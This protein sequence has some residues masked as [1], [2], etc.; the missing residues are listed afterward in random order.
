MAVP[1]G[2]GEK[3]LQTTTADKGREGCCGQK[4][5]LSW[6][7]GRAPLSRW[8]ERKHRYARL[9][10]ELR[11]N[12]PR[13]WNTATNHDH[14]DDHRVKPRGAYGQELLDTHVP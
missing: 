5:R 4:P 14:Y 10:A 9:A 12:T 13:M 7:C 3:E 1:P 11:R 8:P 6:G 2:F